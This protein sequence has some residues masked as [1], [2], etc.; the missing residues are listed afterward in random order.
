MWLA[1]PCALQAGCV[2][3]RTTNYARTIATLKGV[4]TGLYP[5]PTAPH[6][7]ITADTLEAIDEMLYANLRACERLKGLIKGLSKEHQ[8]V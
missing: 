2:A 4:L 1:H 5:G 3:A 6:T 8:G 7:P